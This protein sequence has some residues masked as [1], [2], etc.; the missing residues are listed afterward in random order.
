MLGRMQEMWR[1][2]SSGN[3]LKSDKADMD[4]EAVSVLHD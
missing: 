1:D 3:Y 2:M 4:Y